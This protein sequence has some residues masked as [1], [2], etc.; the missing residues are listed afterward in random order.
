MCLLH[1]LSDFELFLFSD[2]TCTI[3]SYIGTTETDLNETLLSH[4][5]AVWLNPLQRA[6]PGSPTRR[7]TSPWGLLCPSL[8]PRVCQPGGVA[9]R[10]LGQ[11]ESAVMAS[12]NLATSCSNQLHRK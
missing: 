8:Y 5:G 9:G 11:D 3:C 6:G 7:Q 4:A 2:Y 1:L 12:G 10:W